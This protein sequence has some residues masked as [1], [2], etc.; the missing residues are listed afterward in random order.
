M[1]IAELIFP[2]SDTEDFGTARVQFEPC[3]NFVVG[4]NGCGKT[5]FFSALQRNVFEGLPTIKWEDE[6]GFDDV[7]LQLSF[8]DGSASQFS[9]TLNKLIRIC[10]D[11]FSDAD[12]LS[13]MISRHLNALMAEKVKPGRN[14]KFSDYEKFSFVFEDA[15]GWDVRDATSN[16]SRR[17]AFSAMGEQICLTM[18]LCL[19]CREIM[20]WSIPL[21]W[22]DA[23]QGLDLGIRDGIFRVLDDDPCQKI[24]MLGEATFESLKSS[25]GIMATHKI[26]APWAELPE[27]WKSKW[28]GLHAKYA[29]T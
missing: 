11:I 14:L 28:E 22:D 13:S 10:P 21:V 27:P 4:C 29:V 25:K 23:F 3:W 18:A 26:M 20:K 7:C 24:V 12:A 8:L 5:T 6:R 2:W 17:D 9:K 19:G 1:I 16:T 15:L